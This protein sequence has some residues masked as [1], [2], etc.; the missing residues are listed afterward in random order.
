MLLFDG[1]LRGNPLLKQ[2]QHLFKVAY[3]TIHSILCIY[4]FSV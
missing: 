3:M 2:T 4:T 1:A